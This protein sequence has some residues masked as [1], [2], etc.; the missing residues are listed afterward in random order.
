MGKNEIATPCITEYTLALE[1]INN[2]RNR[3]VTEEGYPS[4]VTLPNQVRIK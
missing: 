1:I 3:R 2:R 4:F